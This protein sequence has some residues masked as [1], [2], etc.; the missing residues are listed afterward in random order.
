[1]GNNAGVGAAF[2]DIGKSIKKYGDIMAERQKIM[3]MILSNQL[4]AQNNWFYKQREMEQESQNRLIE[5]TTLNPAE[6]FQLE[7]QKRRKASYEQTQPGMVMPQTNGAIPPQ[8]EG[9]IFSQSMGE[10][11]TLGDKGYEVE[12]DPKKA[13]LILL[14]RKMAAGKKL[15]EREQRFFDKEMGISSMEKEQLTMASQ[16][17]QEFINR[18]EIK[19]FVTINTQV[20]AMD[21]LLNNAIG[22]DIKNKVALDQALIT[23]YNKLTD[24]QSVVRE[25]EYARTPENLPFYNRFFGAFNKLEKGGAGM[26]DDDRKAL[27]WGAKLIANERGQIFNERSQYYGNLAQKAN[28]DPELV[29]GGITE[30]KPYE[31]MNQN[32]NANKDLQLKIQKA[33]EYGYTDEEIQA[34]LNGSK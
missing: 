31:E 6:Q 11:T 14:Q 2:A 26:T 8:S 1:M 27:V 20:K 34:F 24:P 4:T 10:V 13:G 25:S 29:I 5:R 15:S 28:I 19:E 9:D 30:Y 17:R 23:M 32:Q 12:R 16:L 3:A 21:S 7:E 33:K 22:G 18:P